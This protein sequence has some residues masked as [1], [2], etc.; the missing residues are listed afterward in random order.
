M[1][2]TK[3]VLKHQS[4]LVPTALYIPTTPCVLVLVLDLDPYFG[5]SIS[6]EVLID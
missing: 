4:I 6:T 2:N 3:R 1:V 5:P